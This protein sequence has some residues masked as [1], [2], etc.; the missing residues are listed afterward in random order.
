MLK[1]IRIV[2]SL[3]LCLTVLLTGCAN[4]KTES[5]TQSTA[6][7]EI[8]TTQN[9]T[10]SY[11]DSDIIGN[12]YSA[13]NSSVFAFDADGTFRLYSLTA[14]Y[15]EYSDCYI[16]TYSYDGV[17]LTTVFSE[18]T[19]RLPCTYE[20]KDGDR[21][22]L[23]T[24]ETEVISFTFVE[25]P[26]SEHPVY[27]YPDFAAIAQTMD[28]QVP[29]C[30]GL[31]I[32]TEL[33]GQIRDQIR[34]EVAESGVSADALLEGT[35]A[36]GDIVLFDYRGYRIVDGEQEDFEGG[37]AQNQITI[38]GDG[39]G[40]VPGFGQGLIGHGTAEGSFVVEVTFPENYYESLAGQTVYFEMKIHG[41][42]PEVTDEAVRIVT[43]EA[44][45][46]YEA[47][48]SDRLA[49]ALKDDYTI[50][51]LIPGIDFGAVEI[52]DEAYLYFLQSYLDSVH[53][54]ASNYGLSFETLLSYYGQTE[55][56]FLEEATRR[57]M[58]EAQTQLSIQLYFHALHLE[59]NDDLYEKYREELISLY[60]SEYTVTR[61]VIEDYLDKNP[62]EVKDFV[63]MQILLDYLIRE[64][65]FIAVK[66]S[67][68]L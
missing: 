67:A 33:V 65:T 35:V 21:H 36:E 51:S 61:D 12:W 23:I 6:S 54:T 20:N 11:D 47:L 22:L 63:T 58:E 56:E 18:Q 57:A 44:Y 16:G 9:Q 8:T 40:Y 25:D 3:L 32:E 27:S 68:D 29:E 1:R 60:L 14:G 62:E 7:E 49:E 34:K 53:R 50:L 48:F 39:N 5:E 30:T 15:F 52:P 42:Y 59:I 17:K 28:A 31:E 26:P 66:E 4:T 13:E 19:D 55:A 43:K 24:F 64:N 2:L 41:I 37:T 46:S 38:A 45:G 10:P